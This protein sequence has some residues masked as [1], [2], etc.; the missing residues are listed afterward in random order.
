MN[1][2]KKF[3][4]MVDILENYK[5]R[6]RVIVEVYKNEKKYILEVYSERHPWLSARF[7]IKNRKNTQDKFHFY[8]QLNIHDSEL[9]I[10]DTKLMMNFWNEAIEVCNHLNKL[11]IP[12]MNEYEGENGLIQYM[13]EAYKKRNKRFFVWC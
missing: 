6:A 2:Q 3:D 10:K 7:A 12:Y 1:Y 5:Y 9:T 11:R 13:K 8:I 4:T